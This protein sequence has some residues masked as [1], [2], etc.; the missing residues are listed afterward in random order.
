[1]EI[2]YIYLSPLAIYMTGVVIL[3]ITIAIVYVKTHKK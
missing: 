1:M 2:Q 3:G